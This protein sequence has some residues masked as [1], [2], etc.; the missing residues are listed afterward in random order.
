MRITSPEVAVTVSVNVPAGVPGVPPP[1]PPPQEAKSPAK[2]TNVAKPVVAIRMT[3]ATGR[4]AR[5]PPFRFRVFSVASRPSIANSPNAGTHGNQGG[6]GGG[7]SIEAAVVVTVTVAVAS[8]VPSRFT[9][10]G[11]IEQVAL[12]G[13][14]L[15]LID[16]SPVNSPSGETVSI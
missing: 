7:P 10:V 16:A 3:A 13:A 5:N 4:V 14:P 8:F 12:R 2:S 15:K 6:P 9:V 1:P 11:A